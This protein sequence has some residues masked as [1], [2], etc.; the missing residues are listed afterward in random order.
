MSDLNVKKIIENKIVTI[1]LLIIL[2][3]IASIPAFRSSVYDGHDLKFH[4]GRIQ[5]IAEGLQAGQ[6]PVRYEANAWY[7]HGYISSLFYGNIFLYIPAVLYLA[8][9]PVFRAYNIYLILVNITTVLVAYYSFKEL[10]KDKVLGLFA[11]GVYTLYGYRLTNLYVRAALGEYTA[12]IFI[13]LCIYG[14]YRIYTSEKPKFNDNLPLIIAA[15]GLIESHVLTTE[16]IVLF[17]ILFA[18]INFRETLKV[19]RQLLFSVIIIVG[20]NSF[21]IV[22]F[23]MSYMGMKLNINSTLFTESIRG[24]G[25]YL[26]QLV[27]P[28]TLGYGYNTTWLTEHEECYRVGILIL[29]CVILTFIYCLSCII[30]KQKP[31]KWFLQIT[32]F[33]LLAGWISTIYFPW[34]IMLKLGNVGK[35]LSS[36]QYPWRYMSIMSTCFIISGIYSVSKIIKNDVIRIK[37]MLLVALI[38]VAATG[39]FDYTL[40]FGKNVKNETAVAEWADKLYLPFGTDA[41]QLKV[42]NVVVEKNELVLPVLAYDNVE[43]LDDRGVEVETGISNN[44][45]LTVEKSIDL[46]KCKVEYIEPIT[47]R[48][49]EIITVISILILVI[50]KRKMKGNE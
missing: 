34:D 36:V 12:M 2:I 43:V 4:F 6:F 13:P 7:G 35:L 25:L 44:N 22:P 39:V 23:I 40:S 9:M 33:G 8:G 20:I 10:F 45:C 38:A 1:L 49:S 19:F 42:E 5:A 48:L 24:E 18:L 37:V 17:C 41:N 46:S 27:H 14:L 29:L 16:I 21:F 11:T 50:M 3:L 47:W 31:N 28:L 15:T 26:N 32:L 30:K